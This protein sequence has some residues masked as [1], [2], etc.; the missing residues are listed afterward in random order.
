MT[1]ENVLLVSA[2][3]FAIGLY[4]V[5]TR[6]SA[7]TVLMSLEL[8]FNAVVIA[9]I[10]FSRFTVPAAI[11]SGGAVTQPAVR[12][13]LTGHAFAI[14]IIA[15]AAAEVALGLALILALYRRRQTADITDASLLRN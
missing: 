6:R 12:L 11:A 13:A 15:V 2:V 1:L 7:I 10:A 4:G 14:F 5:L 8:M 9:A 3:I